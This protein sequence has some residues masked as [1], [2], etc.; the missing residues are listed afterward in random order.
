VGEKI[1]EKGKPTSLLNNFLDQENLNIEITGVCD[2]YTGRAKSAAQNT[3]T[4]FRSG[5]SS[6]GK[7]MPW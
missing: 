4:P 1:Y 2:T 7:V 6:Q 3:T 5:G